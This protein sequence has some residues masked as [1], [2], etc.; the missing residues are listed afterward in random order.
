MGS[1]LQACS[2]CSP[3]PPNDLLDPVGLNLINGKENPVEWALL[4]YEIDE[5]MEHLQAIR[6]SLTPGGSIE[7]EDY[8][9]QLRHVYAHINR[10]WN[11]RNRLG[12]QTPELFE[13]ESKFPSDLDPVG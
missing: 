7:P 9:V 4:A 1:L 10:A 6:E 13:L 3:E 12:E 2:G 8:E 11:S 5:V